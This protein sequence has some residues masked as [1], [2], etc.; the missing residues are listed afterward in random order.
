MVLIFGHIII[1]VKNF[2]EVFIHTSY[3]TDSKEESVEFYSDLI[4]KQIAWHKSEIDKL[5]ENLL[6][7][8]WGIRQLLII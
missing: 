6:M 5:K 4:N 3:F 2:L 7:K 1:R 8:S